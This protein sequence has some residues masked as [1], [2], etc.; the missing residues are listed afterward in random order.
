VYAF[1]KLNSSGFGLAIDKTIQ[2]ERNIK[3]KKGRS[4]FTHLVDNTE[5]KKI[6]KT[7]NSSN[8]NQFR[9]TKNKFGILNDDIVNSTIEKNE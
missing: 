2:S 5:L 4:I 9:I 8:G 7:S 1:P 6:K 3:N